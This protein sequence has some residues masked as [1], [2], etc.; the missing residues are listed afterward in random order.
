[1]D[2]FTKDQNIER[3]DYLKVDVEGHETNFLKGGRGAISRFNPIIQM[4]YNASAQK[5]ANSSP[6]AILSLIQD[7]DYEA[8]DFNVLVPSLTP[9][10]IEAFLH[11]S[12]DYNTEFVLKPKS[13]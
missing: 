10:D 13:P 9:L 4:E 11:R 3:L 7:M 6:Q 8:F 5:R 2:N 12:E 1:M